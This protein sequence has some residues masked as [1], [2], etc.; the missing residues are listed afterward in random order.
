M[1]ELR[2]HRLESFQGRRVTVLEG[3]G[4]EEDPMRH[5]TYWFDEADRLVAHD[6]KYQPGKWEG[7]ADLP[8]WALDRVEAALKGQTHN[9][10]IAALFRT[11]ASVRER[12]EVDAA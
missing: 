7:L 11:I 3:K 9:P 8:P 10:T 6:D 5:V 4:V 2:L 1:T 12:A